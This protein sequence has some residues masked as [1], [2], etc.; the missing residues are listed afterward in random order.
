VPTQDDVRRICLDLPDTTIHPR[1]FD[2]QRSGRSYAWVWMQRLDPKK[3]R[4][5]NPEVLVVHTDGELAKQDLLTLDPDVIF[6]EPH[7]D[8]YPAVL[9]RLPKVDSD[10]LNLLIRQAWQSRA[11]EKAR[12]WKSAAR[13]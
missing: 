9:V 7:Y 11:P 13:G 6:T 1:G 8:G 5:A 2:F 3:K 4:V 10:L 12:R